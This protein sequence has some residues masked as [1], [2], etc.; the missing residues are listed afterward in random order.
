MLDPSNKPENMLSI[1]LGKFQTLALVFL[2]LAWIVRNTFF[3]RQRSGRFYSSVDETAMVQIIIVVLTVLVVLASRPVLLWNDLKGTSGRWWIALYLFGIMSFFWSINPLFSAYRSLEFLSLSVALM[4]VILNSADE[5]TAEQNF[6][7]MSWS[8]LICQILA[9]GFSQGFSIIGMKSNSYGAS[10]VMIACYSWGETLSV[11]RESKRILIVSGIISTFLVLNSLSIASWWALLT[12]VG[13]VAILSRQKLLFFILFLMLIVSLAYIDQGSI[14]QASF[15]QASIEQL[16]YRYKSG[17][18]FEQA[19][20]GRQ[21]LW[22]DYWVAFKKKPWVGV[23]FAVVAREVGRIYT[24]NTHNFIF[25]IGVGLGVVGLVIFMGYFVKLVYE[26]RMNLRFKGMFAVG[27][28][29]AIIASFVNGMSVS[30][31]GE[32]WVPPSYVFVCLFSL[33]L[34][35]SLAIKNP[36]PSNPLTDHDLLPGGIE[37]AH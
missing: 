14:D 7:M 1:P 5:K 37:R 6:L 25:A 31:I 15:D 22:E 23:G 16:T 24:T 10:A 3:L 30:F 28:F 18:T 17:M 21:A 4:L 11:G 29:A 12:G 13:F 20:S 26:L 32:S 8:V 27:L 19:L 34:Y 35:R 9:Q 36:L 33:H 2:P